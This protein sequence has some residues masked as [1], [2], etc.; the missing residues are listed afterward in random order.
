MRLGSAQ[1]DGGAA[2]GYGLARPDVGTPN[3]P[4]TLYDIAS[5]SKHVTAAA[6]LLLEARGELDTDHSIDEYLPGVP[7]EHREVT[8]HHLLTHTSG[9]GRAGPAGRGPDL[10][11]AL[12]AYFKGSRTGRAGKRFEYFNGGYAMLAGVVERVTG[13][14]FEDWVRDNLFEPAGL[15]Q[16]DFIETARV[17]EALLAAAHGSGKLT[18]DYIKGWGYK[19]MG[20][21][22]TSVSDLATWCNALFDGKVLPEPALEKMLTVERD[23]YACGWYVFDT[24]KGRRVV[25]HGGTAPGF[26][27]YVRYFPDDDVLILVLCNREGWY[28]QVA[29]GL[30]AIVLGEDPKSASPPKIAAL[31]EEQLDAFCGT[32]ESDDDRLYVRRSGRGLRVGG[33]GSDIVAALT[34]TRGGSVGRERKPPKARELKAA[35]E[36]ALAIMTELREGSCELLGADML[37]HIPASWPGRVLNQFWPAHL[38]RWGEVREQR[39]LGAFFDQ[40]TNRTRVWIRLEHA[41]GPRS[42]EIAFV[43]DKLNIFDLNARAYPVDVG[44]AP[45]DERRLVGFDFRDPPP[46]E[47]VL[48]GKGKSRK[49]EVNSRSGARLELEQQK[50]R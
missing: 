20:G 6:I 16:T 42:V 4:E 18:T 35:E 48:K 2:Q 38:E 7:R 32:W 8:L 39:S 46:Y 43:G 11:A 37:P 17:D 21:V 45:V 49:L 9:F 24:D 27:S 10:E 50:P 5:A 29:W 33:V 30:S 12:Q 1:W 31:S 19:G 40:A 28:W 14:A 13:E 47:L 3:T 23:Q 22:L 41:K 15:V 34:Y 36:R 26:Q 25:Q 44:V